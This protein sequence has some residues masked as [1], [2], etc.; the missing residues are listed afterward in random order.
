[1]ENRGPFFFGMDIVIPSDDDPPETPLGLS[2]PGLHPRDEDNTVFTREVRRRGDVDLPPR[3]PTEDPVVCSIQTVCDS[4]RVARVRNAEIEAIDEDYTRRNDLL[5]SSYA[6]LESELTV[7]ATFSETDLDG[8]QESLADTFRISRERLIAGVVEKTGDRALV[9]ERIA[10]YR[11]F[12][13]AGLK[14]FVPPEQIKAHVCPV[15]LELE[16]NTAFYPCG[17]VFCNHCSIRVRACPMCKMRVQA[18][19]RI[20]F[21]I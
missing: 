13:L 16:V 8:V 4:L 19:N 20:F 17:H 9:E 11:E 7:F 5:V 12:M 1:M 6:R 2:R 14:E 21:S 15:C 18:R 3:P 10:A